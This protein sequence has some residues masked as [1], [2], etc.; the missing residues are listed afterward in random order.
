MSSFT[1]TRPARRPASK[2]SALGS[3][4][5]YFNAYAARGAGG[6]RARVFALLRH[7]GRRSGREYATPVA[8]RPYPGG[9]F[10][11]PLTFGTGAD[12]YQNI[13][14]AGGCAIRWKGVEHSL[15]DPQV[16]DFAESA[17]V[18]GPFQRFVMRRVLGIKNF[19]RL[20]DAPTTH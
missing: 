19:A 13:A 20:R 4:T 10:I 3:A 6:R 7:R 17:A 1:Q 15:V 9:G 14:A 16:V 11:I 18:Y 5:K 12:W 2:R 8:A